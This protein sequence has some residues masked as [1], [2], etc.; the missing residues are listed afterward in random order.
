MLFFGLLVGR[1]VSLGRL[2]GFVGFV[3]IAFGFFLGGLFCLVFFNG[4]VRMLVGFFS[5]LFMWG[6]F[7]VF[8][9]VLFLFVGVYFVL[10]VIHWL[11]S[12]TFADII[13][14]C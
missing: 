11:F 5:C 4:F 10:R 1:F 9:G 13:V 6:L 3:F 12:K 7:F 8:V 2:S 14:E